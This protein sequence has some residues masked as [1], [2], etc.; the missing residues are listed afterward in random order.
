MKVTTITLDFQNGAN[1]I[2]NNVDAELIGSFLVITLANGE[3]RAFSTNNLRSG[4]WMPAPT[5][6][7]V[8]PAQPSKGPE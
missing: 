8:V 1:Q 5:A 6:A 4:V 3:R 7:P 2:F